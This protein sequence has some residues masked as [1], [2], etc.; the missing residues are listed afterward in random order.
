VVADGGLY[1]SRYIRKPIVNKSEMSDFET[2]YLSKCPDCENMNYSKMPIGSDGIPCAI[3]GEELKNRD[4]YKSIEPR[5]GF[6]AEE[7]VKDVPL[8]SQERKYKTEA[9]YIGDKTAYP[10]SKYDYEFENIKLEVES[11]ANDSLVV[12]STD[13]FYVCPKCGYSIASDETSKLSDYKDYRAGVTRIENNQKGHKNPFGKGNCTITSLS[14]YCLHHE[15]KTDV[16]KISFGCDTSNQ[17][18]MMSVMYA[19]L[20]S[21]ANELNIERR[22]IKACLTYK[23]T[24]GKMEHKIIIYDAVPGGAGHSRRLV[25]E[26]GEVLKAVIKRAITLLNTCE[27]SPSCY[28]CL[29]NYENQKIHEILDREKALHF[30]KQLDKSET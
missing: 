27:C 15:F 13:F 23:R 21:F 29:R 25:T 5:A 10:I 11:T 12:K 28:R 16:A 19:L 30:L 26:D 6:I 8:S 4:F 1:K 3:C 9:I 7:D 20:N 14:K 2:A 18:T 22:D 24:K 17:A